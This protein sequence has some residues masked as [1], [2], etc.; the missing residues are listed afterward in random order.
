M[1]VLYP[2]RQK[3]LFVVSTYYV[4]HFVDKKEYDIIFLAMVL[5]L[6]E[7]H[8]HTE[9][10]VVFLT[11]QSVYRTRSILIQL[12]AVQLLPSTGHAAV[13][14]EQLRMQANKPNYV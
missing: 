12:P 7:W 4:N 14:G 3:W 1:K 13:E 6:V 10:S 2:V 11:I 5:H 9:G 8:G